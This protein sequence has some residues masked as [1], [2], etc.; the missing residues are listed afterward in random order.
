M[1]C[2]RGLRRFGQLFGG[3]IFQDAIDG[4]ALLLLD[5]N[6]CD[7]ALIFGNGWIGLDAGDFFLHRLVHAK[8]G[9]HLFG[10]RAALFGLFLGLAEQW[11]LRSLVK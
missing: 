4:V 7:A 9:Q 5:H 11:A 1:Y 10:R 6:E 8:D 3:R 2:S